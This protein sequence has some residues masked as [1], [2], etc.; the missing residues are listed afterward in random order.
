MALSAWAWIV[1]VM[2][3]GA[4]VLACTTRR[5]MSGVYHIICEMKCHCIRCM[6]CGVCGVRSSSSFVGD[7][8]VVLTVE[9][10]FASTLVDE[11]SVE[12][13]VYVSPHIGMT[14]AGLGADFQLLVRVRCGG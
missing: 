3:Y 7:G 1:A 4:F 13:I 10:K 11:T 9:K 6:G 2:L 14:Y 5:R 8:G 12:R